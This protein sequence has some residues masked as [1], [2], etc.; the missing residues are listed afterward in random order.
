[1]ACRKWEEMKT[2]HFPICR[3]LWTL[4]Q[5]QISMQ[6]IYHYHFWCSL[7]TVAWFDT[8]VYF[9]K[10]WLMFYFLFPTILFHVYSSVLVIC[11][12]N[13]YM[14]LAEWKWERDGMGMGMGRGRER[15]WNKAKLGIGNGNEIESSAMG[16]NEINKVIPAHLYCWVVV[17]TFSPELWVDRTIRPKEA[18]H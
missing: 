4:L 8:D 15:E 5:V 2:P 12:L 9:L 13:D 1:M 11:Y 7:Y 16:G 10:F 17:L 14:L 3:R 18:L 6:I